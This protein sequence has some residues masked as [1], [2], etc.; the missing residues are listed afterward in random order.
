M[1][2]VDMLSAVVQQLP[3]PTLPMQ[4]V[5]Q[6]QG[7]AVGQGEGHMQGQ[8]Q[9]HEGQE[10][11]DSM[12]QEEWK[13]MSMEEQAQ[14]LQHRDVCSSAWQQLSASSLAPYADSFQEQ[15]PQ[16]PGQSQEQPQWQV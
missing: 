16:Q 14:Y 6:G 2:A 11:E 10:G 12:S 13:W 8:G 1:I 15:P 5:H 3:P 4:R 9:V 7:G